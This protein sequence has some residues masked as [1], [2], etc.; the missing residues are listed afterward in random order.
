M[1]FFL[2]WK[3]VVAE[4]LT[5]KKKELF[6][7]QRGAI[8]FEVIL[9][10][11]DSWWS[12]DHHYRGVI[13]SV[14]LDISWQNEMLWSNLDFVWLALCFLVHWQN[15]LNDQ[16]FFNTTFFL[17][18]EILPSS[19]RKKKKKKQQLVAYFSCTLY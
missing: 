10:W 12:S 13:W 3:Y 9:K 16:S 15:T 17:L 1:E 2:S 11:V 14:N 6:F 8:K 18:F 5:P 4:L 19:N 7:F